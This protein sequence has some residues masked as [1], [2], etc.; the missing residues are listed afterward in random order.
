MYCKWQQLWLIPA[1]RTITGCKKIG[2]RQKFVL[3]TVRVT[4]SGP[5]K[6]FVSVCWACSRGYKVWHRPQI[7]TNVLIPNDHVAQRIKECA[8]CALSQQHSLYTKYLL[9]SLNAAISFRHMIYSFIQILNKYDLKYLESGNIELHFIL[10][11][12]KHVFH[13]LL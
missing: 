1:L 8:V 12:L 10:K 13:F 7:R 4:Y 9:I 11:S 3:L 6:W 2:K 5:G